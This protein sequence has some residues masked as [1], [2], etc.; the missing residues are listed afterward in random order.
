MSLSADTLYIV[1]DDAQARA[2]LVRL[3][4]AAGYQT[5]AFG[6]ASEFLEAHAHLERAPGCL[7]LDL[8]MPEMS[9]LELQQA[10]CRAGCRRPIVFLSGR[11]DISKSVRAMKG[12]AV[13]FLTK[14]VDAR[15]L[16]AAVE[17]AL[18]IDAAERSA[19]V[20]RHGVVERIA[21]LTP[22]ERQVLGQLV[23]GKI[24]KQIAAALGTAEKTVKVHRSRVMRKMHA[25]SIVELVKLA[26]LV[27]IQSGISPLLGASAPTAPAAVQP[28]RH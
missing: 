27:G 23:S 26:S 3:L 22:R 21:T 14:P 11:G 25:G 17:E 24:N 4:R 1:D 10:L 7:L 13:N 15:E 5:R 18:A 28:S 19:W 16:F 12:G 8:A 20:V 9:G 2:A 6:S